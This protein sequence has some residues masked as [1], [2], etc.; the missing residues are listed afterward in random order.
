MF[1][2]AF[3]SASAAILVGT[4]TAGSA[5]A[6]DFPSKPIKMVV[7]FGA[8][9]STDTMAR[10]FAK[11][12]EKHLGERVIVVNKPGA[13]GEL[14]WTFLA[15][16]KADGYTIGLINSPVVEVYPFTRAETVGY[17]MDDIRP[18]VNVVTDPGVLAV[19]ADGPFQTLTDFI[20]FVQSHPNEVTVSHE[21]IGGDDHL[22]MMS[23]AN[24]TNTEMNM[25]SFSS[26]AEATAALL[27]GHIDAFEGNMSEVS[28]QINSGTIKALAVWSPERLDAIADVPTGAEQNV[29]LIA[30]A[31]RGLAVPAGV[32]DDVYQKLVDASEAV[33]NDEEFKQE[34][35]KLNM[36]LNP[37]YGSEY[38][39]FLQDS[40]DSLKAIWDV[41][42][43]VKD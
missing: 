29:D 28:A 15:N 19:K 7:A 14:G 13:G 3:L 20:E 18:L 35:V 4:L 24:K 37:I 11:Y 39:D 1:K 22:A 5:M 27:G 40:H 23:F 34:L 25:V 10:I 21:G 26:N 36:P 41:N 9:G 38:V 30:A 17:S 8:G 43:W 12:A 6:A 42:P 2:K 31:S 16:S 33:I 32:P